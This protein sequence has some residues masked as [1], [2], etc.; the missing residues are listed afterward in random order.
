MV[1][2]KQSIHIINLDARIKAVKTKW[3]ISA[4][5]KKDLI[6]FLRDLEIGKVNKGIKIS[7]ARQLKY[8]DMLKIPLEHFNKPVP[9]LTPKDTENFEKA[10]ISNKILSW[11]KKPLSNWT[12]VDIKT[13]LKVYLKWKLGDTQ[14]YKNLTEFF[15][16]RIKQ[17]TP[18]YLSEA[19]AEKL[20]KAC[21]TAKERFLVAVLFDSGSRA[22][23]FFNIRKEDIQLPT[24]NENYVKLTLK[25][26]YSKTKGIVISLYWK[27]SLDAVRDYLR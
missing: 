13:I 25:E 4:E 20:F 18:E 19:E 21:K 6:R 3:K 23:E 2:V 12:K 16:T 1:F 8:L 10:L 14:Q 11:K 17:A 9:Q 7:E 5:D 22:E 26:E 27:H 15:D 24:N